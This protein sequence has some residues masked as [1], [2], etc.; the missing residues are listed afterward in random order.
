MSKI[1][2]NASDKESEKLTREQCNE[3]IN[4][5]LM[6]FANC[7]DRGSDALFVL[8][9]EIETH[10][11]DRDHVEQICRDVKAFLF[12]CTREYDDVSD[13]RARILRREVVNPRA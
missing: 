2:P 8:M 11:G 9:D 3:I 12:S 10:S 1:P 6:D 4:W 5:Q 7:D 13:A